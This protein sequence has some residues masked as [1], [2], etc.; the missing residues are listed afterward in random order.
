M[1]LRP[2]HILALTLILL[3]LPL[4]AL[5]E[6]A[7]MTPPPPGEWLCPFLAHSWQQYLDWVHETPPYYPAEEYVTA[8][9]EPIL[10]LS[11]IGDVREEYLFGRLL[12]K[13]G[14]AEELWN[15]IIRE[16]MLSFGSGTEAKTGYIMGEKAMVF[17]ET[18]PVLQLDYM[19]GD[20]G[21]TWIEFYLTPW[22]PKN[23]QQYH[24]LP[25]A[26]TLAPF[27][28]YTWYDIAENSSD[29]VDVLEAST[30]TTSCDPAITCGIELYYL[31]PNF[32]AGELL[33]PDATPE[34]VYRLWS[35]LKTEIEAHYADAQPATPMGSLGGDKT[36]HYAFQSRETFIEMSYYHYQDSSLTD[37]ITFSIYR[38]DQ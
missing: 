14:N 18:N 10:Y 12:T 19:V 27:I 30:Y 17:P 9:D 4:L 23:E 25:P 29:L 21:V 38:F 15:Q 36:E 31:W 26:K 8:G 5:A 3:L 33:L 11:Q 35:Q 1:P 32:A 20:E 28:P 7:A 24:L 16:C 22:T 37:S 34:E 13:D 6:G 2:K